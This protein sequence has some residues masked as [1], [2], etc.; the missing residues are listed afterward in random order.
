MT[1]TKP[2]AGVLSPVLTPFTQDLSPDTGRF[3]AHC[4]WLLEQGANGLAVFGTTSEANSLSVG[5]RMLLLDALVGDGIRPDLLMPGTGCCSLTDTV[6]LTSHAV[7]NG[8]GGVLLLPPFYYKAVNEDGLFAHIAEVI[9]RVGDDRLR[10]YLYHFPGIAVV[11]YSLD[12]IERL[13]KAY[14]SIVI[15]LKDSSGDW[16]NTQSVLKQFP[17]LD[18]FPG[19]E[20]FL[21]PA[22]RAGGAG[23]ITATAN[24]NASAIRTLYDHWQTPE[25]E[26]LQGDVSSLRKM[27]DGYP[28]IPALKQIIANFRNDPSWCALR[29]PLMG[30]SDAQVS[31]LMASLEQRKFALAA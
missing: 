17:G 31:T 8:C 30:L 2:F 20:V 11:C 6:Q 4:R 12:L 23:C 28:M 5:E 21:L 18:V 10:I 16:S 26:M 14:P 3:V 13:V 7:Q 27:I 25:A 9:E 1:N 29:P 19:S 22:L 24:V 15:G